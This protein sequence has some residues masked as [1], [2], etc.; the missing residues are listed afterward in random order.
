MVETL[1]FRTT[2]LDIGYSP[3]ELL[4]GR[5]LRSVLPVLTDQPIPKVINHKEVGIRLGQSHAQ[6]KQYFDRQAR[7][8]PPIEIGDS[9]RFQQDSKL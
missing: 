2:P 6:Q 4:Q 8:L 9:V 1:A 7:S 5:L 3:S